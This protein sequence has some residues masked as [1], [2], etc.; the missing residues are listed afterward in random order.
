MN[1]LFRTEHQNT[2]Q[3][4]ATLSSLTIFPP[5]LNLPKEFH[6]V[7]RIPS[8]TGLPEFEQLAVLVNGGLV[9][10]LLQMVILQ[11]GRVQRMDQK[12]CFSIHPADLSLSA[13][14]VSL[15]ITSESILGIT[16]NVDWLEIE[17]STRNLED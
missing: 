1:G 15:V 9:E 11:Y 13:D 17:R 10:I 4:K 3:R 12:V 2:C 5:S 16:I 8:V 7:K 6:I 14:V